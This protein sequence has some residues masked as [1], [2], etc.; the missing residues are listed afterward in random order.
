[1]ISKELYERFISQET[2]PEESARVR[3]YLRKHP[4]SL[5]E[6]MSDEEFEQFQYG[7]RLH[8]VVSTG[9][10]EKIRLATYEKYRSFRKLKAWVA[11]A[12][13]IVVTGLGIMK[14][15]N[16]R[17]DTVASKKAPVNLENRP[18]QQQKVNRTD[19]VMAIVLKDG[20]RVSL[21]PHSGISYT[22]PFEHNKRD[23]YL[24]GTACFD[25]AHDRTKS[26]TVFTGKLATSALGTKFLIEYDK[27]RSF[28]KVK[29]YEGKVVVRSTGKETG[30]EEKESFLLPGNELIYDKHEGTAEVFVGSGDDSGRKDMAKEN[31]HSL[32]R[33][34]LQLEGIYGVRI[35]FS[36]KEM[37]NKFFFGE[38]NTSEPIDSILSEIALLNELSVTLQGKT[39]ILKSIQH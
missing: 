3:E 14:M 8:P 5:D 28:I 23:I 22:E 15:G 10:Q 38:I 7:V 27:R 12:V 34:L 18:I 4:E 17:G 35:R 32:K 33:V 21:Q 19:K 2:T 9:M 20:S 29:L 36:E 1:M 37:S 25:V 39:Y 16:N 13:V 30:K 11:A 24:D 31:D 6:W 26:F